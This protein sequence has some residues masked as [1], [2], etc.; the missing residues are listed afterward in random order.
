MSFVTNAGAKVLNR[1]KLAGGE[2]VVCGKYICTRDEPP[3]SCALREIGLITLAPGHSIGFHQHMGNEEAYIGVS[4]RGTY[5]DADGKDYSFGPGDMSV[6]RFGESHGMVNTG[7]EPL[8]FV[9][10]IGAK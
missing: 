4:G 1:E 2:G 6:V 5:R 8:V 9:A 7:S 3:A 10:V